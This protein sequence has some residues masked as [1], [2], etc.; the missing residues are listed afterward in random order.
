MALGKIVEGQMNLRAAESGEA[1]II[2]RVT[3]ADVER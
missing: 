2:G 1:L 3:A